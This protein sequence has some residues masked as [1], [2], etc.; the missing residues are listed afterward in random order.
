MGCPSFPRMTWEELRMPCTCRSTLYFDSR[1]L[2][3]KGHSK[4]HLLRGRRQ[5]GGG[6]NASHCRLLAHLHAQ[7]LE[8]SP[9]HD[10]RAH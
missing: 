3:C 10:A 7:L 9:A 5:A 8:Q 6:A 2:L 4:T 1:F